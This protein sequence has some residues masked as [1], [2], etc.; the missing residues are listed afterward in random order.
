MVLVRCAADS[1]QE[2]YYGLC[3]VATKNEA[4]RNEAS[5]EALRPIYTEELPGVAAHD[6]LFVLLRP[7]VAEPSR[8]RAQNYPAQ[9]KQ[10]IAPGN[11][12]QALSADWLLISSC[13]KR[14]TQ[15]QKIRR[16]AFA[17]SNYN[18]HSNAR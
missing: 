16:P 13:A 3:A 1:F 17:A 5:D 2:V 15:S 4:L 12:W 14:K 6:S 9:K 11:S 7:G 18:Q 8:A 10:R